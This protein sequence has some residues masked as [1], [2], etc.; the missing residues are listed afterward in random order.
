M[1]IAHIPGTTEM[2]G[3]GFTHASANPGVHVVAVILQYGS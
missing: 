3:G 2:L 1:P